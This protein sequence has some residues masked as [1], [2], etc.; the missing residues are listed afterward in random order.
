M[1]EWTKS[2]SISNGEVFAMDRTLR[3]PRFRRPRLDELRRFSVD[4]GVFF[5]TLQCDLWHPS[6][7]VTKP[8]KFGYVLTMDCSK[9]T[10]RHT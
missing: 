10:N 1:Q 3:R 4:L 5:D 8:V 2:N 9:L 6:V 7:K